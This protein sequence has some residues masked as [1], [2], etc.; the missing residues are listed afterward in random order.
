M[1]SDAFAQAK[2]PGV[3]QWRGQILGGRLRDARATCVHSR[4]NKKGHLLAFREA[5]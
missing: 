1:T 4:G 3:M 2:T 5:L